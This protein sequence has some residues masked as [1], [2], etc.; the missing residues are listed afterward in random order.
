MFKPKITRSSAILQRDR[1]TLLSVEMLST[2][3]Q[4][5]VQYIPVEKA[6]ID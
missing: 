6:A 3:A 1:A 4:I 2:G 5:Y